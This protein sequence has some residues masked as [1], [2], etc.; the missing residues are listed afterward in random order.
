MVVRLRNDGGETLIE[1]IVA[2]AIMGIAGVAVMTG[3]QFSVLSSTLGRNQATSDAYVRTL[4]EAIQRYVSASGGYQACSTTPNYITASV[5]SQAA[6]PSGYTAS[7]SAVQNWNPTT[8]TWGSCNSTFD[9]AQRMTLTVTSAGA[10]TDAHKA[11]EQLTF[12]IR[13]PCNGL[14]PSPC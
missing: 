4:A 6:L 9:Y 5:A 8:H 13:R 12:I 11:T 1:L 3:L 2:I 14:L 7:Q 10:A